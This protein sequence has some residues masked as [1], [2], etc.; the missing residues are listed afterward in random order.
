MLHNHTLLTIKLTLDSHGHE[1]RHAIVD[2][3]LATALEL[4]PIYFSGPFFIY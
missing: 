2:G 3:L 4:S 1:W